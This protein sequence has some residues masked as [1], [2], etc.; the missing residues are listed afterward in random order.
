MAKKETV[1]FTIDPEL[2]Q[3]AEARIAAMGLS[4]EE[5]ITMFYERLAS[6]CCDPFSPHIPN[7]ETIEAMEQANR[8][9]GLITYAS[10]EDLMKDL[11]NPDAE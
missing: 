9:E 10:V 8:G 11:D 3:E 5:A 6:I 7:A 4:P 2:K 1:C